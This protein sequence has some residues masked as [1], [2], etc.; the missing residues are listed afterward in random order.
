MQ[1][2]L[3]YVSKEPRATRAYQ[4]QVDLARTCLAIELGAL[5]S[6]PEILLYLARWSRAVRRLQEE[7]PVELPA[8]T[9]QLLRVT[10]RINRACRLSA[11]ARRVTRR[12][13]HDGILCTVT[14]ATGTARPIGRWADKLRQQIGFD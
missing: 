3:A 10:G 12:A 4:H 8:F 6:P 14:P 2:E 11:P 7:Y 1:P 5:L 13:I 9:M